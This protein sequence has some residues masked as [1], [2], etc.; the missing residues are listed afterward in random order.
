MDYNQMNTYSLTK[1]GMKLF[2]DKRLRVMDKLYELYY[3]PKSGLISAQRLYLKLNKQLPI[4]QIIKFLD[5]QEV[6]QLHKESRRKP[7]FSPI[8]V[9]DRVRILKGKQTFRKGYVSKY[10][11]GIYTVVSGNGYSFSISDD[12]GN[13]LG[14]SYKYYEL[15]RVEGT[16]TFLIEPRHREPTMTNKERRNKRELQELARVQGPT[17]RKT[18]TFGAT[19]FLE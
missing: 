17:N 12:N 1:T 13:V 8:T 18:K 4:S 3:S 6:H 10:S 15:E 14:K 2:N 19:Y 5:Q 11:N 7:A 9:G 16:E